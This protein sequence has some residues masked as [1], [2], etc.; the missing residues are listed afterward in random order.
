LNIEFTIA[1]F[2]EVEPRTKLF[3]PN[4]SEAPTIAKPTPRSRS[5][6]RRLTHPNWL[7]DSQF[8]WRIDRRQPGQ[9]PSD[10]I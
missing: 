2:A 1:S 3:V 5:S 6:C 4:G 7:R 8:K 10:A 9:S